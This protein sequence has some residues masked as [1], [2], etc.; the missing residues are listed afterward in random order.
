MLRAI[1]PSVCLSVTF[2]HPAKT[3][4]PIDFIFGT[5]VGIGKCDI[6]LDSAP[7]RGRGSLI[8]MRLKLS[9]KATFVH[10][11]QTAEPID[12]IF[13]GRVGMGK[14]NI[15][16]NAQLKRGRGSLIFMRRNFIKLSCTVQKWLN[17]STSYLVGRLGGRLEHYVRPSSKGSRA[18]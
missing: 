1:R 7:A 13:G 17:R 3:A 10:H 14:G 4:E 12:F 11:S 15:V 2:V 5:W 18:H 8:F 16:L 6:M 9:G